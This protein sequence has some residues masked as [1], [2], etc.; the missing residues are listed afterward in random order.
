MEYPDGSDI[1]PNN[2]LRRSPFIGAEH[3]QKIRTTLIEKL[4]ELK[5]KQEE[6]LMLMVLLSCTT[7]EISR[8]R[9]PT[10]YT[11]ISALA[12]SDHLSIIGKSIIEDAK[13]EISSLLMKHFEQQYGV[14]ARIRYVELLS[15]QS[16]VDW[17]H[18]SM[19]NVQCLYNLKR[20]D[21]KKLEGYL[22]KFE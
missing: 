12:L 10:N 4:A 5:I 17:T 7:G 18:K 1:F 22:Y 2:I 19:D 16:V 21:N 14:A 9:L 8:P 3:L 20:T 11:E 6:F 13:T 15:V